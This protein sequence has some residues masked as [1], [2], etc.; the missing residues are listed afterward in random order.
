MFSFFIFYFLISYLLIA[1]SNE[2]KQDES[3][4]I[5]LCIAI[6]VQIQFPLEQIDKQVRHP[7]S[8]H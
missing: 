2:Y 5:V 1:A 3:K 7:M 8:H 6:M 4:A